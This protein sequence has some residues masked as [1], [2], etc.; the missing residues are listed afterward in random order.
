[1][2]KES[3]IFFSA[4]NS[5]AKKIKCIKINKSKKGECKIGG[6]IKV[7]LKKYKNKDKLK[8]RSIYNGL[9]TLIKSK[10]IRED[11]SYIRFSKNRCLLFS[12]SFKFLGTRLKGFILKELSFNP[13]AIKNAPKIVTYFDIMI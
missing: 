13:V 4:D 7:S 3:M 2:L 5:G 10:V 11:G 12:E 8:K 9:P 1:M 6:F